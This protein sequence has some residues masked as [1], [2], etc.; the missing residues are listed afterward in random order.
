MALVES[1]TEICLM[2]APGASLLRRGGR[3]HV[4]RLV[5]GARLAFG[6]V[7][8]LPLHSPVLEPDLDLALREAERVRDL[9]PSPPRQVPVEV[10]LLLQL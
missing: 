7:L 9:D 10:E 2:A 8:L 1:E 5:S 6:L 3:T 4:V